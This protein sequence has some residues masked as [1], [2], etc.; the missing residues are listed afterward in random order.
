[1]NAG[2]FGGMRVSGLK[3]IA[4]VFYETADL[5]RAIEWYTRVLG[6]RIRFR[7]GAWAEFETE[8][9]SLALHRRRAVKRGRGRPNATAIFEVADIRAARA[10][11]SER[12]VRL[13]GGVKPVGEHGF[14]A[15][16]ADPDGNVFQLWQAARRGTPAVARKRKGR[17]A[18]STQRRKAEPAGGAARRRR[19]LS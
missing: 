10:R 15:A 16:F 17:R 3:R 6:L 4:S 14:L 1:M 8:G 18:G 13:V 5:D 12:G 7:I 19:P 11:L 9:A 2:G